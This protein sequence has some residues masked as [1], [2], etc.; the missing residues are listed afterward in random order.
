MVLNTDLADS[1]ILITGGTKGLG[2]G[3]VEIFAREGCHVSYCART[4]HDSDFDELHKSLEPTAHHVHGT[5]VDVSNR[6]ALMKWVS[7]CGTR[8]GRID[9]IIANA[10]N[11]HFESTPETWQSSFDLDIMGFVNLVDA[12]M[13]WLEKSPHP[14]ILVQSSF[15]G[16][17]FFRS[18]PAPYG[19]CKAAQLQYVQE[20]SHSLGPRGIRVNAIS[21]GPIWALDGAWETYSR[22]DPKWVD[23]QRQKVP[24]KRFG[25]PEDVAKVAIFLASPLSSYVQGA[26]VMVDG[27]VHVG[28]DF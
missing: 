2:R 22:V 21:P 28:T 12:S 4:V 10:S 1:H 23:E 5:S 19:A 24:L 15:M 6:G 16:R 25:T 20:L 26:N 11:M 17:E 14:S 3:M 27:G 13:P 8:I 9:V 18:P 7:D